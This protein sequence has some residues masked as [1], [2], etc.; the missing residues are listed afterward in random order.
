[1]A[2][3]TIGDA[4]LVSDGETLTIGR[5]GQRDLTLSLDAAGVAELIDFVTSLATTEFNRRQ[6]FRVPIH[7]SSGLSVQIRK[8]DRL[9]SVT[10]TNISITGI[11]IELPRDDW[12]DFEQDDQMSVILEFEGEKQDH[13]GVVRRCA[14]NGYG[15][16]F[17]KSM[18]GNELDPPAELS[19]VVMELQRRWMTR[20]AKTAG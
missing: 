11:F 16:F 13:R 9:I 2:E 4:H 3:I 7:H 8:G 15:L 6:D 17:P 10:P 20:R 5:R 12:I 19:R 1:M 14:D 18:K